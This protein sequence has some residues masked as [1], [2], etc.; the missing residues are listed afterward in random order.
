MTL[1]L[2]L[3]SVGRAAAQESPRL[4]VFPHPD[5][6][7][8]W[9]SAQ[10]NVIYQGHPAFPAA[11]SGT[12][13]LKP[14]AEN[15]VSYVATLYSGIL[16]SPTTELFL[17][18]ESAGGRGISAA[19][20]LAGFTNLDVVRNPT[21]SS[22]PYLARAMVRQIFPLS[23]E[24]VSVV[25]GPLELQTQVP[26]KRI[27][28]IVGHFGTVDFFDTNDVAG[29]SH[30]QFLNWTV[31]NNGA[32][33]YAADTRGYSWGA[34]I[35]YQEPAFGIRYAVMMMPKVANGIDL[36]ADLFRASGHNLEGE[37]RYHLGSH[38]GVLRLLSYLNVANMGDY[39]EAIGDFLRGQGPL[40]SVVATRHQGTVKYGFGLN[41]QQAVGPVLRF[42]LRAG[43]NE[44]AHE[45]FAYTEVNDSVALG[46]DIA[47]AAWGRPND[48]VGLALV[49]NG[50]S[51]EHR[52]YLALGGLGFLLGDGR[53]AYARECIAETYY[54]LFVGFGVFLAVD[55]QAIANP[56]YNRARGP[57]FVGSFRFHVEI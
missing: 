4:S 25:R 53:L 54:T 9:V 16:I 26:A 23:E 27:E 12:N 52:E 3:F 19:F 50:L 32:Y 24:K 35:Q 21:L 43:W 29:D 39:Q 20:G 2:A 10:L 7:P 36:D 1:L 13:S 57:V 28:L 33:D 45:S 56:G 46:G 22:T 11:Y 44:G 38:P 6:T 34:L 5:D 8:W 18:V 37:F 49:S 47:G 40:P 41:L 15:A 14:Y 55:V 30:L 42:F 31:D 17:D 51:A 48:K